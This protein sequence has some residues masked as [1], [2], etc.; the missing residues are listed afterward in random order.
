M[1]TTFGLTLVIVLYCAQQA[2]T[3][4]CQ[5]TAGGE[6][7]FFDG[8]TKVTPSTFRCMHLTVQTDSTLVVSPPT[9]SASHRGKCRAV[10]DNVQKWVRE[11]EKVNEDVNTGI[12]C[13]YECRDQ[14]GKFRCKSSPKNKMC[15]CEE[16]KLHVVIRPV[17]SELGVETLRGQGELTGGQGCEDKE[18]GYQFPDAVPCISIRAEVRKKRV[19]KTNVR[20]KCL[21]RTER[22][23]ETRFTPADPTE[24]NIQGC[25]WVCKEAA[26]RCT[27]RTTNGRCN[28]EVPGLQKVLVGLSEEQLTGLMR[29]T[30]CV[31]GGDC[32]PC[33]VC[34]EEG[35]CL[36]KERAWEGDHCPCGEICPVT[37]ERENAGGKLLCVPNTSLLCMAEPEWKRSGKGNNYR[38][39]VEV[40]DFCRKGKT[41]M[42]DTCGC[43]E[44][45][46]EYLDTEKDADSAVVKCK[47]ASEHA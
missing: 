5:K 42:G 47:P 1:T 6:F 7:E 10:H 32:G 41:D 20:N 38:A 3:L 31:K 34:N 28:C 2:Y 12:L 37:D 27:G 39:G 17:S 44:G 9:P 22:R 23:T 21:S 16:K 8:P 18:E 14:T 24:L 26:P 13:K 35:K 29:Q 33:G 25:M 36:L 43:R 40:P 4:T 30:E 19:F 11:Y 15:E 45:Y 46:I